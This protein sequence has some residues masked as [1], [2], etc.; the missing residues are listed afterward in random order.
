[1]DPAST[2]VTVFCGTFSCRLVGVDDP[3]A[4][5]EDVTAYFREVASSS[6]P[7]SDAGRPDIA[8]VR[9]L[10]ETRLGCKV[11]A[12]PC[13]DGVTLRP[14]AVDDPD[15]EP[16]APAV[17]PGPGSSGRV[18]RIELN[19][20]HE[21]SNGGES[22][23]GNV[24]A[25]PN[26]APDARDAERAE[27]ETDDLA[28]ELA[29]IRAAEEE[30]G[31]RAAGDAGASLDG[32]ADRDMERLFAATDSRIANF[33]S[34]RRQAS[35]S[36]LKAAVAARRAEDRPSDNPDSSG[37]YRDDLVRSVLPASEASGS[38]TLDE[39]S[40]DRIDPLV[41]ADNQ[42]IETNE[43]SSP[44]DP[45]DVVS[46]AT[47]EPETFPDFAARI[48]ATTLQDRLEAA[49]VYIRESLGQ[50][51]FPRARV[52]HL[53]A[54]TGDPFSRE[55]ALRGFGKLLRDGLVRK[56]ARGEFALGTGS[57]FAQRSGR[58]R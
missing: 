10:V 36:H 2:S 37:A 25:D 39:R 4:A 14:A 58:N 1:M 8:H 45:A 9:H 41:L 7:G 17:E 48:G 21:T 13:P 26:P 31:E 40:E 50:E 46:A 27:W 47:D 34:S 5:L 43:S 57:R 54:E 30:I 35:L 32:A 38:E 16:P 53:A 55:D 11:D 23:T 24:T 44:A 33:D 49:A 12:V 56:V 6:G 3:A 28:V 18:H 20:S 15:A 52:L 51:L 29:A 42:R 22:I 19:R